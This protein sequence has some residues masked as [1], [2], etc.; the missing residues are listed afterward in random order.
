MTPLT[1]KISLEE[2]KQYK[3]ICKSKDTTMSQE[4]R[5]FIKREIKEE[6]NKKI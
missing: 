2:K 6:A 5:K 1:I 3:E 4:I